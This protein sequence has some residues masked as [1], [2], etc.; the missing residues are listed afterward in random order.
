M[1][2]K[3]S[4]LDIF[5]QNQ[6]DKNKNMLKQTIDTALQEE[7]A[8]LEEISKAL[9]HCKTNISKCNKLLEGKIFHV[10]VCCQKR[11]LLFKTI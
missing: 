10:L 1:K 9:N 6:I 5:L 11:K 7:Q 2:Y 3:K 4:P 8:C